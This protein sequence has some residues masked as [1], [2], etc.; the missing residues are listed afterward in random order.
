MNHE[1]KSIML[2]QE[3]LSTIK[4]LE[5]ELNPFLLLRS[6]FGNP[7]ERQTNVEPSIITVGTGL[8][9]CV[10]FKYLKK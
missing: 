9:S 5:N 3:F 6:D 4:Y 8:V 2:T 10:I 7:S 1:H